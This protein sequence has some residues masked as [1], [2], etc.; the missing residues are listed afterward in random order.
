MQVAKKNFD[1]VTFAIFSALENEDADHQRLSLA[2]TAGRLAEAPY[3]CIHT[4]QFLHD[5]GRKW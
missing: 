2:A 5:S 1:F 3:S 4:T